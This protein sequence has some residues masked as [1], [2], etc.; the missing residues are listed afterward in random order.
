MTGQYLN[1]RKPINTKQLSYEKFLATTDRFALS[2]IL[3]AKRTYPSPGDP[4]F[5]RE[6]LLRGLRFYINEPKDGIGKSVIDM[7][8]MSF[9]LG[10]SLRATL[11]Q[12]LRYVIKEQQRVLTYKPQVTRKAVLKKWGRIPLPWF[13][14]VERY[15]DGVL[16]SKVYRVK[17]E[18]VVEYVKEGEILGPYENRLLSHPSFLTLWTFLISV[19]AS[20]KLNK[21]YDEYDT[22]KH[23]LALAHATIK[24]IAQEVEDTSP[25]GTS[26]KDT[27]KMVW[28][29]TQK[30]LAELFAQLESK[31]WLRAPVSS[32]IKRA[33][34]KS[35]SI[36]QILKPGVIKG[37][38]N[39]PYPEIFTT[40]YTECFDGISKNKNL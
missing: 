1:T 5:A 37:G 19:Y 11:I 7:F 30:Q 24:E 6:F 20:R 36:Q 25:V 17:G 40:E 22:G 29:G 38:T 18:T 12:I 28:L 2:L 8:D 4:A 14:H 15:E 3:K 27:K 31:G 13:S 39:R 9:K 16:H 32:A 35:D 10:I 21:L 33:F 23:P 34:T 26:S